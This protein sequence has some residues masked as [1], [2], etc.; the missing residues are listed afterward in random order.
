LT[1][2]LLIK[3]VSNKEGVAHLDRDQTRY[4]R[5]YKMPQKC[6]IP[7]DGEIREFEHL[8][9]AATIAQI[10]YEVILTFEDN[11]E[12]INNSNT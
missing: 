12:F 2:E 1:R 10:A 8:T 11:V 5:N 4:Y 6:E 9:V 7:V 3:S